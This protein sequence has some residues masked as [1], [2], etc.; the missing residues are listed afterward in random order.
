MTSICPKDGT[1]CCDDLCHGGGCIQMDG[2]PMLERC[3]R[4]GR[5]IDEDLL[6]DCSCDEVD[7]E[8]YLEIPGFL[9]SGKD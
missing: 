7:D 6:D 4:C 8:E 3:D 5:I 1:A 9:R 2:Y